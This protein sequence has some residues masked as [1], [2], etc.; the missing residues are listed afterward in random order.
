[1]PPFTLED[2]GDDQ[3][4]RL[5][6]TLNLLFK[7]LTD[8]DEYSEIN[9]HQRKLKACNVVTFQILKTRLGELAYK[10]TK[11]FMDDILSIQS[12]TKD[13]SKR[14]QRIAKQMVE[15]CKNEIVFIEACDSCYELANADVKNWFPSVCEKQHKL[16]WAKVVGYP[17]APAKLMKTDNDKATVQFFGEHKISQTPTKFCLRFSEKSPNHNYDTEVNIMQEVQQYIKNLGPSFK[18]AQTG[19]R[20]SANVTV[21]PAITS[22][23]TWASTIRKSITDLLDKNEK[24]FETLKTN[25]GLKE[26]VYRSEIKVLEEKLSAQKRQYEEQ[27]TAAKNQ[28]YCDCCKSVTKST[29]HIFCSNTCGAKWYGDQANK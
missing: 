6:R 29:I 5:H 13:S 14:L 28:K 4:K 24:E 12:M 17:Y 19:E 3:Q 18:Y 1:M 23:S 2:C 16:V 9:N 21:A 10:T 22:A 8:D 15:Y 11:E 26:A 7:R 27:L 20:L 25:F